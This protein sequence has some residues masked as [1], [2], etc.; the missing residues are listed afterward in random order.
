MGSTMLPNGLD[1]IP[2]LC[3]NSIV[4]YLEVH[5]ND[6]RQLAIRVPEEMKEWL[7]KEAGRNGSSQNSEVIRAVRE[8]MERLEEGAGRDAAA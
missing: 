6:T 7:M 1:A 5:M 4:L 2:A 8:R 3:C